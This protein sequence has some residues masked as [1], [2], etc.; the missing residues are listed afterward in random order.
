MMKNLSRRSPW[1][2]GLSLLVAI[3]IAAMV[4]SGGWLSPIARAEIIRA[5]KQRY[6]SDIEIQSLNLS[7]FPY[8]HATGAGL[9]FRK[10]GRRDVPPMITVRAFT[11]DT[12]WL[13][14]LAT[15]R[16]VRSVRLDG[17]EIR[18]SR[19]EKKPEPAS[20]RSSKQPPPRFMIQEIAADGTLLQI[21]PKV[22][23]KQPLTFNIYK[24]QLHSVSGRHAMTYRAQLRNAKP[25]GMIEATGDFGPWEADDPGETPVTGKYRFLNADLGVFKGLS[26][27]LSSTGEFHGR[28]EK[29][30][31]NGQTDTPD[32]TVA[33]GGHPVDLKTTFSATVDGENGD[34]FLHP[35]TA[36]FG[37]TTI[38][39]QGGI[40]GTPG[41]PGKTVSLDSQVQ[42]GDLAD[43]LRLG[44]KS[45]P[46]PMTGRISFHS[47]I[48]IPPGERDIAAK[49]YLNGQFDID[50]GKFS[51]ATLER[52]VSAFSAR[53]QGD[54]R[55]GGTVARASNMHGTFVLEDGVITLHG[56]TFQ[57][58]GAAIRLNGTYGL[59]TEALDFHGT[60]TMDAKLSQMTTG[61]KSVLLR[62]LDPIFE[63]KKKGAVIPIHI[64]GTR[65][66]PSVGL[67]FKR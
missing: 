17:L 28:L 37:R 16:R 31:V 53:A 40:I 22:P 44:V 11:A 4:A 3:G 34:T 58:P 2:I 42:N 30:E 27:K 13:D 23:G 32:F 49:L 33:A 56:L 24:L 12:G 47:Q 57:L 46:P 50:S 29:I 36:Y 9:V 6:Q 14:L 59:V 41:I 5:L 52:R 21:F 1:L 35:V 39:C 38:V 48:R 67:E 19:E 55:S 61:I 45:D 65:R 43:V 8:P 66:S 63:T 10:N 54:T 15:P 62:A 25:P 51:S 26:G 20:R 18:V 64:G 7:L 60:V